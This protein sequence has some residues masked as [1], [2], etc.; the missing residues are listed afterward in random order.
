M[1]GDSDPGDTDCRELQ[2]RLPGLLEAGEGLYRDHHL[3][4]CVT[5]RSL[6][7]D[8]EKIAENARELFGSQN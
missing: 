6:V 5:C 4:T 2:R 7:V 1:T 8:L 3:Q